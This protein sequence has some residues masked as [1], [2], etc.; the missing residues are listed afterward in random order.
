MRPYPFF[1]EEAENYQSVLVVAPGLEQ[2][3]PYVAACTASGYRVTD[4]GLAQLIQTQEKL[5]DIYGH[6]RRTVS[7]GLYQLQKIQFPVTY[8]IG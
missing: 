3:R 5:A 7:I 6:K 4:E 1:I 2:V 8:R